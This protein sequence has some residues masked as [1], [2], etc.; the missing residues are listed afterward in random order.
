MINEDTRFLRRFKNTDNATCWLNSCLQLILN[1]FDYEDMPVSSFTSSLGVEIQRLRLNK[2]DTA[3]DPTPVKN[4]LSSTEDTRVALRLSEIDAECQDSDQAERL[5]SHAINARFNMFS[6][7]QFIRDL[8][9][10]L[11]VNFSKD[12]F[13]FLFRF[14]FDRN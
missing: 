9:I 12:S 1:C 4:I 13:F 8:F 10:C 5:K 11:Q 14:R 3:L 7:Q 2:K 6:G